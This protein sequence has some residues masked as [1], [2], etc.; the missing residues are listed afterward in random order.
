MNKVT[1]NKLPKSKV[2]IKVEVSAEILSEY[3]QK[4]VE[5]FV[6]ETSLPGFRP[7]QA[8]VEMVKNKVGMSKIMDRA[9]TRAIEATFPEIIK[10]NKLEPLGYPELTVQKLAEGNTLE[11][12]AIVAVYPQAKL[13]D[14]K[15]I[16]QG[17]EL[18]KVELTEE[19][20][21]RLKM[22][23]ERHL[24]EHLREDAL[25]AIAKETEVEVPE[26]LVARETEK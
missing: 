12:T 23:K 25:L 3:I 10:E 13:P 7:G 9:A 11:Y 15:K 8:P 17:F 2:E 26:I 21:K 14:Y 19:D 22:E 4:A 20:M 16:A 24:L 6:K 18:G 1:I 5:E